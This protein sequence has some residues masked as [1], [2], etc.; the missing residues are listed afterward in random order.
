MLFDQPDHQFRLLRVQTEARAELARNAGAG[1][2]MVL[3][4]PLGDVVEQHRDIE[5]VAF[6]DGGHQLVGQRMNVGSLALVDLRQR[7]HRAEQVL[8]HRIVVIHVE[9]HHRDDPP[10]V[11]NEAAEHARLVHP[12]QHQRRSAPRG[13]H[14][15]EQAVGL[16]VLANLVGDQRQGAR[17]AFQR[18]RVELQIVDVGDVEK[19]DDVDRIALEDVRIGQRDAAAVLD[20]IHGSRD[21]VDALGEA[22]DDVLQPRRLLGLLVFERGAEDAGQIADILG[23]EEIVLHEAFD[24]RQA[25]PRVVAEAFRDLPLD[26]EGQPLLRLTG[27]KVHVAAHGPEKI[28]RLLEDLPLVSRKDAEL[29]EFLRVANAVV[30]FRDPEKRVQVAQAALAFLDVRLD[31]IARIARLL[32]ALVALGEL[33]GH[34]FRAGA[35]DDLRVEAFLQIGDQGIVTADVAAFEDRRA[36]RHVGLGQ[37]D[38][39]LDRAGGMADLEAHVPEHVEQEFHRLAHGLGVL[40]RQQE[41]KIDV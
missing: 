17:H 10:E 28:V 7:F 35:G 33:G 26:V 16:F 6:L 37:L 19:P 39:F 11:R 5:R 13:Q 40:R 1:D 12:P 32:V 15:Q 34:E 30:V 21:L 24:G 36:D 25:R 29:D 27:Q 9:L 18:V 2:G 23:D 3:L 20:E 8:I 41:E 4:S 22:R 31:Q 38:A 14:G